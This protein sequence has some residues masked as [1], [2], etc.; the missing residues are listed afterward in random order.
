MKKVFSFLALFVLAMLIAGIFGVVHDQV[1]F[2]VSSEYFTKFKFRQFGFL[3][4]AVP[5]RVRVAMIGF[6][7]SWYMGIPIGLVVGRL[8]LIYPT[9]S[10]MFRFGARS[11]GLLV[12]FVGLIA[13]S[14]LGFGYFRTASGDLDRHSQWFVPSNILYVRRYL[15]AGYMHNA[16]YLGG[17]VGAIGFALI[18]YVAR[19]RKRPNQSLQPTRLIALSLRKTR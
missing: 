9:T 7:A 10:E 17:A 15:C 8:A 11:F 4:P 2:T 13:I 5:E 1:S 19:R 16:A 18:H 3:D 14:G 12:A 6:L